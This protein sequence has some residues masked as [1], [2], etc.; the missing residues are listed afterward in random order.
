MSSTWAIAQARPVTGFALQF[1]PFYRRPSISQSDF[2]PNGEKLLP[3][4]DS[5]LFGLVVKIQLSL[6]SAH[7]QKINLFE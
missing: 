5:L 7:W 2:S 1:L 4:Q 6:E 3:T